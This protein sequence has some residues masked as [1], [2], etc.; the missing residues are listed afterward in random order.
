MA[1]MNTLFIEQEK[2]NGERIKELEGH[3]GQLVHEAT[4]RDRLVN[5]WKT[6]ASSLSR[7]C[8]S[9]EDD[10]SVREKH[11]EEL[12]DWK[13]IQEERLVSLQQERKLSSSSIPP[14]TRPS[15]LNSK[16]RRFSTRASMDSSFSATLKRAST[17]G[18]ITDQVREEA[19]IEMM[20]LEEQLA[21]MDKDKAELL[22][23][24]ATMKAILASVD[25]DKDQKK[26]KKKKRERL[27]YQLSCRKCNKQ[28]NFV[29]TTTHDLRTTMER[30]FDQVVKVATTSNNKKISSSFSKGDNKKKKAENKEGDDDGEVTNNNNKKE[31]WSAEFAQHFAKH[32]KPSLP[33]IKS[34]SPKEVILF[35][36]QNVKVEVLRRSDGAEL[37]WED[38]D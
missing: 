4:E 16:G 25:E 24:L 2:E 34:V 28:M 19:K 35:C 32:V 10:A 22:Q 5:H 20:A 38:T 11:I 1:K 27:V 26:K 30:H 36:Q 31:A 17:K 18:N 8:L 6:K 7:K 15:L 23:E 9:L 13:R 12:E 33:R 29:G 14:T 3:V 37:Y 21:M